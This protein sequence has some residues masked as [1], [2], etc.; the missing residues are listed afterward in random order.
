MGLREY[1]LM[2]LAGHAKFKTTY[3]FD[4]TVADDLMDRAMKASNEAVGKVLART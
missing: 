1:E 3:K 4:L 2:R